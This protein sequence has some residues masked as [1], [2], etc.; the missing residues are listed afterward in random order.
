[1]YLEGKSVLDI[2]KEQE[3]LEIKSPV[4]KATWHKRT[5]DVMLSNGKYIG[6]V[7]LLDKGDHEVHYVSENNHP[8]IIT[9]SEFR[10]V[11]EEKKK[12]SNIITDDDGKR[13][14]EK[15]YEILI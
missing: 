3:R 13:R 15:R 1:M 11:Q 2:A 8:P 5:I 4:G 10:D 9:E 7:R 6:M 12:R 14:S